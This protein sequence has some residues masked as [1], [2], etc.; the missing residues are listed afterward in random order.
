MGEGEGVAQSMLER[1]VEKDNRDDDD[2]E[3]F[4]AVVAVVSVTIEL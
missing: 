2:E 4:R 1:G 3:L